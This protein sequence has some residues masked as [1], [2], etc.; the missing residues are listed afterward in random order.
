[1]VR[2]LLFKSLVSLLLATSF[3]AL[4][5]QALVMPHASQSM[6]LDAIRVRDRLI[7]AGD[8]GHIL[9]SDDHGA[10]WQQAE[11]PTRSLL[12]AITFPSSTHGWAVGHNGVIL[13]TVD[14]GA[15]WSLQR[16]GLAAQLEINQQSLVVSQKALDT[17]REATMR[18]PDAEQRRILES[19]IEELELDVEDAQAVLNEAVNAPP[20]L[21]VFFSDERHGFAV[22]AFNTFLRT[23]DGGITWQLESSQ[24][25]NPDEYHL[26]AITGDG[27]GAVWI[28]AEGGALFRSADN[29]DSWE[30]LASPYRG[31]WFGIMNAPSQ[32]V[33]IVFGLRGN[34]YRSEDQ[35]NSWR[36]IKIDSD[37]TLAGGFFINDR[38][39][40]LVGSVGTLLISNDAA[41]SFSIQPSGIRKHLSG[42]TS[43]ANTAFVVGQGGVSAIPGLELKP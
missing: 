41:N 1:M 2:Q 32:D 43:E 37:R 13:S 25:D 20:L 31:S 9:Y 3:Q 17:A 28:A 42:V 40:L 15:H 4:G 35:G 39:V 26:N 27:K 19:E 16:D 10:S 30:N 12:T 38:S 5:E 33:L 29:G 14:G 23:V 34:V 18:T 7:V 11:V 24:L 22:G 21:D 36:R 6:L 8:Y